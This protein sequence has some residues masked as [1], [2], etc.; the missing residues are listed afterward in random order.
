[1]LRP[2]HFGHNPK[3]GTSEPKS[4]SRQNSVAFPN[5]NMRGGLCEVLLS[6]LPVAI[7]VIQFIRDGY[8]VVQDGVITLSNDHAAVAF[9]KCEEN[10]TGS[11]FL[12]TCS[13]A[14]PFGCWHRCLWVASSGKTETIIGKSTG[15]NQTSPTL[16][17]APYGDGLLLALGLSFPVSP[18]QE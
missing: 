2:L 10:L 17:I 16:T 13:D 11:L 14:L 18:T 9:G 6:S 5:C 15:N 12:S 7:L 8:D 4:P 1:M 3:S